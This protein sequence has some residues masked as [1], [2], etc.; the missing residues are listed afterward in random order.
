MIF[1]VRISGSAKFIESS[2]SQIANLI[3]EPKNLILRVINETMNPTKKKTIAYF[4]KKYVESKNMY[5]TQFSHIN[6]YETHSTSQ[7][8][9]CASHVKM[10]V[11]PSFPW[12]SPLRPQYILVIGIYFLSKNPW[13]T[14][15]SK[16]EFHETSVYPCYKDVFPMQ[17]SMYTPSFLLV[18]LT[19]FRT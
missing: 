11:K 18:S 14:Q 17:R 15:F 7:L 4:I 12:K 1:R 6:V 5:C 16:V 10:H 2:K 3:V 8:S 9:G 19:C 13:R